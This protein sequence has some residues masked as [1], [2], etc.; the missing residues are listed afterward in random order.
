MYHPSRSVGS[1]ET[2]RVQR[3]SQRRLRVRAPAHERPGPWGA[4]PMRGPA[5]ERPS[6][7]EPSLRSTLGS[8]AFHHFHGFVWKVCNP[9]GNGLAGQMWTDRPWKAWK[10]PPPGEER[11]GGQLIVYFEGCLLTGGLGNILI[12]SSFDEWMPSKFIHYNAIEYPWPQHPP[13]ICA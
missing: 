13:P 8:S 10:P 4:R 9:K 1:D 2:K 6:P 5:Y 3:G 11:G 12:L 7:W